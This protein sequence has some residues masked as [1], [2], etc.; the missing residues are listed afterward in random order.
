MWS[1]TTHTTAINSLETHHGGGCLFTSHLVFQCLSCGSNQF[2]QFGIPLGTL[3]ID[4]SHRTRII[5]PHPKLS[6]I[7]LPVWVGLSRSE[8]LTWLPLIPLGRLRSSQLPVES[9]SLCNSTKIQEIQEE[10]LMSSTRTQKTSVYDLRWFA[11]AIQPQ[12]LAEYMHFA[13][14]LRGRF[15]NL[16]FQAWQIWRSPQFLS[17]MSRMSWSVERNLAESMQWKW[18][19]TPLDSLDIE[20]YCSSY[21]F[22]TVHIDGSRW[23][24]GWVIRRT[25]SCSCSWQCS[26]WRWMIKD[27]ICKA[28]AN[29]G[30]CRTEAG[31]T[32]Q[33]VVKRFNIIVLYN[34][35]L[36]SQKEGSMDLVRSQ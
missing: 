33:H 17:R 29:H 2:V 24:K 18:H 9:E 26:W 21:M 11:Q 20:G 25:Q 10:G 32:V 34:C 30:N 14:C 12:T 28:C 36:C 1:L 6:K 31:N 7:S 22:I 5:Q 4:N 19:K 35:C 13:E 3:G 27:R 16:F 23:I 8:A 15:R